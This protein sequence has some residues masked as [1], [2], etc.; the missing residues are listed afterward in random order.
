MLMQLQS[1][2]IH[3]SYLQDAFAQITSALKELA[4][5]LWLSVCQAPSISNTWQ[6]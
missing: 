2:V 3:M 5:A 6:L 4:A 1:A